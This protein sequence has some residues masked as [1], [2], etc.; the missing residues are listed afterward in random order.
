MNPLIILDID[1]VANCSSDFDLL[2][3]INGSGTILCPKKVERILRL[4]QEFTA[5]IVLSSSWR[6]YPDARRALN[7]VG[8]FWVNTTTMESRASGTRGEEILEFIQEFSSTP[9]QFVIL[10]DDGSVGNHDELRPYFV[11]TTF[12]EG[13]LDE[14]LE[15]ARRILAHAP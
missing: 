4:Q 11:H 10:D 7:M 12:R 9:F 1:G 13:F 14:H 5:D 15:K 8:I 2:K 3:P 6:H